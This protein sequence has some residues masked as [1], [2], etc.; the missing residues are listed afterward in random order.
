M[1]EFYGRMRCWTIH[2]GRH[3]RRVLAVALCAVACAAAC[4]TT[5]PP[6]SAKPMPDA[7][8]GVAT[9]DTDGTIVLN[10][11]ATAPGMIGE[12]NSDTPRTTRNATRC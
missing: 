6:Q 9:M 7:S 12:R 3:G 4:A 10:L 2:Y 8:I 5:P 11:R 1:E